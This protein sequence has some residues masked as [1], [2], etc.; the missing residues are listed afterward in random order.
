MELSFETIV[1]VT[2]KGLRSG[3]EGPVL[4]PGVPRFL[5]NTFG[6]EI[7]ADEKNEGS[8]FL[9]R[10]SLR[11]WAESDTVE[12]FKSRFTSELGHQS[13]P[14]TEWGLK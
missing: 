6:P 14:T 2:G 5:R 7:S 12:K 10:L 13:D 9:T 1:V 3:V 8:F 11:K 4:R